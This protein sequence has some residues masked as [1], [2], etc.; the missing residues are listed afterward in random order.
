MGFCKQ[1]VGGCQKAVGQRSEKIYARTRFVWKCL[2]LCVTVERC[3]GKCTLRTF[4]SIPSYFGTV[5][6]W[7]HL[8]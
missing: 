8:W 5:I 6:L 1:G 7:L 3:S 4:E 2:G